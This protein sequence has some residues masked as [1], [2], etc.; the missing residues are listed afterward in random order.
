MVLLALFMTLMLMMTAMIIIITTMMSRHRRIGVCQYGLLSLFRALCSFSFFYNR[1]AP[2]HQTK[3]L[4]SEAGWGYFI[5]M[6][7]TLE[8]SRA[9]HPYLQQLLLLLLHTC[10]CD[11]T[12]CNNNQFNN[13]HIISFNHFPDNVTFLTGAAIA[14]WATPKP[15]HGWHDRRVIVSGH[16]N[17]V[18]KTTHCGIYCVFVSYLP[19]CVESMNNDLI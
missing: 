14:L 3:P 17:I 5:E 2:H 11:G 15:K 8:T 18:K 13:N 4:T 1:I 10:W 16:Q 19:L 6:V 12:E 9:A 7:R